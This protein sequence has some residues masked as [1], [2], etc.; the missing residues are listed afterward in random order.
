[1]TN[2]LASIS[3]GSLKK[4]KT[5]HKLSCSKDKFKKGKINCF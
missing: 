5:E 3:I 2:E 1:M 4:I